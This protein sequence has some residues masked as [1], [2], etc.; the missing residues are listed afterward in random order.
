MIVTPEYYESFR[1]AV[2][3]YQESLHLDHLEF[4]IEWS[5]ID[6][7]ADAEVDFGS[8][9]AT[10]RLTKG[11]VIYDNPARLAYHECMEVLLWPVRD[12]LRKI[13]REKTVDRLIHAMINVSENRM[14]REKNK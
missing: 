3:E 8:M 6:A 12:L 14:F 2:L 1:N 4:Q 5:D 9:I 11:D 10:I 7:Q 13:C